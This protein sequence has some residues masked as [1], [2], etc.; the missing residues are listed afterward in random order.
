MHFGIT[1]HPTRDCVLLYENVGFS[2]TVGNFKGGQSISI[3]ENPTVIWRPLS[4]EPRK[5]THKPS[6]Q[7]ETK[8]IDRQSSVFVVGISTLSVIFM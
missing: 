5:Y 1:E 4:R 3:F 7:P 2:L 6:V 8:V